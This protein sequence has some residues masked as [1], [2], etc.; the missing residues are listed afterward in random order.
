MMQSM[1][2]Y[3]CVQCVFIVTTK[4]KAT[5]HNHHDEQDDQE[6]SSLF[7]IYILSYTYSGP[8]S[9][10]ETDGEKKTFTFGKI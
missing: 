5:R 3:V 9:L 7:Y 8:A 2:M 1:I 4:C 6:T 10:R